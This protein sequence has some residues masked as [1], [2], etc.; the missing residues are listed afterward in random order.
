MSNYRKELMVE[1]GAK[2]K[3]SDIDPGYHGKHESHDAALP[4]IQA[5][6]RIA[7]QRGS[8]RA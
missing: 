4:E 6:V 2:L 5:H 7:D 8:G 1:P 3:L